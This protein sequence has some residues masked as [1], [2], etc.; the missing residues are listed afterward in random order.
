MAGGSEQSE[1][2]AV[3]SRIVIEKTTDE[4][5]K[6]SKGV[7]GKGRIM[8]RRVTRLRKWLGNP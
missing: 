3:S 8:S 4:I 5:S 1:N 2:Y 6:G 7:R